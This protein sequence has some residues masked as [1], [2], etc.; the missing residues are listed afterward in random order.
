MCG[1]CGHTADW[2]ATVVQ[3]MNARLVH[4]GP[5]DEGVYVDKRAGVALGARRL[6]IIDVAGGH[7][8]VSNED[9]SVW[10][11]LNGEIYNHPE[12]Q[13]RL[14]GRGHQLKSRTDTEVLVHLYEDFGDE[15]VH[16][17]EGMFA[18]AIWD[19]NRQRMLVVRDRF[20]EKPLFYSIADDR[21]V[22]AS[23]LTALRAGLATDPELDAHAIDAFYVYGYVPGPNTITEGVCQLAPG[24]LMV[25]DQQARRLT[26]R[27]YWKPPLFGSHSVDHMDAV[28]ETERLLER[29]LRMR[30][31]SDVPLGIF[32]SGGLDST[33]IAALAA[34]IATTPVKTFTVGY[35]VGEVGETHAAREV[36]QAI[37][38]D[39]HE[40]IIGA[41]DLAASVP[42]VLSRMDHPIA[43]QAL[44]ALHAV[45]AT[46]RREI[47]VA[48]GGEGADELFGGYPRYRWL[49]RAEV[50]AA[51]LPE[52]TAEGAARLLSR[53]GGGATA[54]L[55]DVLTPRMTTSR[56]IDWVTAN[57]RFARE[58]VYGPCLREAG[59]HNRAPEAYLE[60]RLP[61]G[62][63]VEGAFMTLDQ[64]QWLPDD[65]L[66]KADRA[67]MLTSLEMR[68]PF[69]NRE[70]AELAASIPL[71]V[72][73]RGGGK[74]ILRKVLE[75]TGVHLA[76]SGKRAFRVPLK[77]WL[78]GALVPLV[79][80]Q[81]E[82]SAVYAEGWFDRERIRQLSDEHRGGAADHSA[83]LWPVIAFACWLDAWRD[84]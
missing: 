35:D 21:L 42:Q 79:D 8:P 57:R 2:D 47:T 34:R 13:Q 73:M 56:H 62:F 16:A 15:M 80:E 49:A 41:N 39:H 51:V 5:D 55:G 17:L 45:A 20:G 78:R 37:G 68:T 82:G 25:W 71:S 44:V 40:V 81:L 75:R 23:E 29:S 53:A 27:R 84:A 3:R 83:V 33:L 61:W 67:S 1:I 46:A 26:H 77:D 18:F 24:H 6:S 12:L 69:L 38:S 76:P 48:V 36:A 43:D 66:Q 14:L 50:V 11:A 10:A 54:R 60:A 74:H 58:V 63:P 9:S 65:V 59:L 7:Q 32:L 30:M 4:R 22:I 31:I 70:L 52:S 64:L 28:A 19:R 72:H